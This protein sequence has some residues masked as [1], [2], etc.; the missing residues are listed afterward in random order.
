MSSALARRRWRTQ[1]RYDEDFAGGAAASALVGSGSDVAIASGAGVARETFAGSGSD[2]ALASGAG[3]AAETFSGSGTDVAIGSGAGAAASLL[4]WQQ[5][6]TSV[7]GNLS[8]GG[9]SD[10]VVPG[11]WDALAQITTSAGKL[12][13]LPESRLTS[14]LV[15]SPNNG[16]FTYNT[17]TGLIALSGSTI[18]LTT[19][20]SL[21][22]SG[23]GP[24]GLIIC[25]S[26]VGANTWYGGY[27]YSGGELLLGG[28]GGF[29]SV[30]SN[31]GGTVSSTLAD[32]DTSLRLFVLGVD[33]T[34]VHLTIPNK[35]QVSASNGAAQSG[36]QQLIT[37]GNYNATSSTTVA[38]LAF[39]IAMSRNPTT[40]DINAAKVYAAS[41]GYVTA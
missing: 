35:S 34:Q 25:A 31:G 3:A 23:A 22:G 15:M 6:L 24:Y 28:T 1:R 27:Y 26:G 33:S 41:K 37:I 12:A 13:T 10:S 2:I 29:F 5:F 19:P 40:A 20:T 8:A 21:V 9:A 32:S 11:L 17:S 7:G 36:T 16:T 30:T 18:G 4:P 14:G 38:T 39:V